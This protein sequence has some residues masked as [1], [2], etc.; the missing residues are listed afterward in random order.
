MRNSNDFKRADTSQ[1]A[2]GEL[3]GGSPGKRSRTHARYGAVQAKRSPRSESP[4]AD[5]RPGGAV[6]MAGGVGMSGA[7]VHDVAQS[8]VLGS[9]GSLPYLDQIQA[10][11]GAH[12]I[13]GV[14]AHTGGA[15]S[16][17]SSALGA[18][19]YATGNDIAFAGTPDLH[20]AAH[21]AAHV[22]Q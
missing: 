11:F 6:Q 12:D 21:E 8:G 1:G 2:K 14:R 7:Q 5:D 19:A 9:G 17:A 3:S 13:S 10:S 15:A 22:V 18:R 20:T 16:A 4:A